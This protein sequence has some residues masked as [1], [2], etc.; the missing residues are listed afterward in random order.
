MRSI[1]MQLN[2]GFILKKMEEILPRQC[3]VRGSIKLTC[4]T[5]EDLLDP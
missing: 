4:K 2:F 5:T 3:V 1:S